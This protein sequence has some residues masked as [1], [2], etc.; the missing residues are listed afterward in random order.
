MEN[1]YDCAA[2]LYLR[3]VKRLAATKGFS[4]GSYIALQG[5]LKLGNMSQD[6]ITEEI[7]GEQ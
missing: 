6:L 5:C 7:Y 1:H 2:S 4:V 3:G